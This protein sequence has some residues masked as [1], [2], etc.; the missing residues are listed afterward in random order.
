MSPKTPQ[1]IPATCGCKMNG[2]VLDMLGLE[3]ELLRCWME[4]AMGWQRDHMEMVVHDP[5]E[6]K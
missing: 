6:L 5:E 2:D 3:M 1:D 4:A